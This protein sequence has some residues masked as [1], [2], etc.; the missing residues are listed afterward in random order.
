MCKIKLSE[1]DGSSILGECM[2][3]K[4]FFAIIFE[5]KSS[6]TKF[7]DKVNNLKLQ[8]KEIDKNRKFVGL[9]IP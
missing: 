7:L 6:K 2:L 3:K 4:V 8:S 5:K 1:E 9:A